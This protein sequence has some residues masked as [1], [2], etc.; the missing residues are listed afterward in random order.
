MDAGERLITMEGRDY[1]ALLIDSTFDNAN[2]EDEAGK[3]TRKINLNRPIKSIIQDLLSNVPAAA[4][5][6][7]EDQEW[8]GVKELCED[9]ANI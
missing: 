7:I 8:P 4:N 9:S 3:R 5:I 6:P 2:L 1:T